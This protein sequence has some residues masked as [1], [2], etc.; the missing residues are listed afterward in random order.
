MYHR[1]REHVT[2]MYGEERAHV[3]DEKRHVLAET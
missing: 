1:V 3:R 2:L